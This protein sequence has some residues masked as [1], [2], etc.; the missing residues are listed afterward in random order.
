MDCADASPGP[1]MVRPGPT[2]GL[3]LQGRPAVDLTL[4]GQRR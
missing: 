3:G 4:G 1:G 2:V